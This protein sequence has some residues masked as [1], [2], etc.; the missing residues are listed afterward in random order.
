MYND[1]VLQVI[2]EEVNQMPT[3]SFRVSEEEAKQL[4]EYVKMNH[5]NLSQFVRES[6]LDRIDSDLKL[7]EERILHALNKSKEEKLYDHME[8]WDILEV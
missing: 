5:L 3:I 6:V 2:Q 8:V 1:F 4:H 7:D